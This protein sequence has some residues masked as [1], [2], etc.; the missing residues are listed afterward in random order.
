MSKAEYIKCKKL[1]EEA[2][3][4]A[5]KA[6]EEYDKSEDYGLE[7]DGAWM[8]EQRNA[9]QHIGEASGIYRALDMLGFT[10]EKMNELSELL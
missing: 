10:H 3:L 8:I 2:L 9:D 1:M 4:K 5:K 7:C 6:H